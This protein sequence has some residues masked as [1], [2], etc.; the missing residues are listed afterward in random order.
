MGESQKVR[1]RCKHVRRRLKL[2]ALLEKLTDSLDDEEAE[3]TEFRSSMRNC[4]RFIRKL[5]NPE[6][7]E[8]FIDTSKIWFIQIPLHHSVINLT[9]TDV[10]MFTGRILHHWNPKIHVDKY[11]AIHKHTTM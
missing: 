6:C 8:G 2:V 3:R 9:L 1:E 7:W 5:L 11:L 4:A 10:L